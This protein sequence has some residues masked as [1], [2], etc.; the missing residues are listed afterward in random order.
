MRFLI[1]IITIIDVVVRGQVISPCF[2]NCLILWCPKGVND[3]T[4]FCVEKNANINAC[5][6]Q[7]CDPAAIGD[8]QMVQTKFC[9]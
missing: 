1:L 6:N 5:A 9:K 7:S 3:Y 4:C 2:N 8:G